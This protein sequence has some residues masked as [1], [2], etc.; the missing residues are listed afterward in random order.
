MLFMMQ[1]KSSDYRNL[2]ILCG[3]LIVAAA[4]GCALAEPAPA[5]VSAFNSYVSRVESRLAQQ[6][7]GD[8]SDQRGHDHDELAGEV[9]GVGLVGG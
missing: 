3:L 8:E 4:P 1:S 2:F 5:A 7:A 6:T 9:G